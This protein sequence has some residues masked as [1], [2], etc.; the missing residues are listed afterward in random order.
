MYQH[1][2]VTCIIPA[3]NEAQAI[4]IVVSSLQ[5]LKNTEGQPLI[6]Q[7]IVCDNGST[8]NTAV[9]ARDSG[10]SVISQAQ[11]GYGIACLTALTK[12]N[13]NTDIVLFT[14]G[15]NA[16][17]AEQSKPLIASVANGADLA[18]G[19]RPNGRIESGALTPAQYFGNRLACYLIRKIWRK[20]VSDLGPFRAIS[21]R[22][23]QQL[24][25]ADKNFGW[26]IEMQ[27][28][29]IQQNMTIVECPI[30]TLCRIGQSKISGT[31]KGTIGAGMG[32]L[33]VIA[34][35]WWQQSRSRKRSTGYAFKPDSSIAPYPIA[36]SKTP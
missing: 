10:A 13:P 22:A 36:K 19:S 6:D 7:L 15:D 11:P 34:K 5:Q 18:I 16:F 8:D 3:R 31:L 23:L 35:L 30:D 4:G 21:Y 2:Y 12:A 24:N 17:R 29:A 28:K 25:M 14:D 33:S 26:T 20:N 27:I 32:I 1:K 9:I